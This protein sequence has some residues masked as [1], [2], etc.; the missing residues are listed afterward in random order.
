MVVLPPWVQE[1]VGVR[2]LTIANHPKSR[3]LCVD[4][5]GYRLP[6]YQRIIETPD[7]E[8]FTIDARRRA[9]IN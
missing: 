5:D 1:L 2:E 6:N 7:G 4:R 8:S 9:I 3:S